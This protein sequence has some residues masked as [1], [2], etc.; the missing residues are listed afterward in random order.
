MLLCI[1]HGL[2]CRY[3]LGDFKDEKYL[4]DFHAMM[5]WNGNHFFAPES[6]LTS[7]GR[8]VMW[9]WQLHRPLAPTGVQSLPRELEL[10]DDGVLRMRPLRE[11]KTLRY[12]EKREKKIS[13][14]AGKPRKL[15]TVEGDA[16][17]LEVVFKSP[18]AKEFGVDV[19]CDENGANGLR[20]AAVPES[21]TLRV[22]GVNAPFEF[23]RGADVTL[24]VFVDKNFVEVFAD[25]RQAAAATGAYNPE[26]IHARLFTEGRDVKVGTATSWKMKSIY[27]GSTV[28]EAD[29]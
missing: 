5:S 13:L 12:E 23:K 4:P 27:E 11:L 3:Y 29:D 21:K 9:A 20:I 24:R 22:G 16:F 25:D 17:E 19:L 15:D 28:F 18:A 2:G 26:N 7:D 6:V 10:P 8:R 1:S 14:E